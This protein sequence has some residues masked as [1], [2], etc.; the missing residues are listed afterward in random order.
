MGTI[1]R[2]IGSRI[3][4]PALSKVFEF[5]NILARNTLKMKLNVSHFLFY[6]IVEK[7]EHFYWIFAILCVS[8]YTW[9]KQTQAS[10]EWTHASCICVSITRYIVTAH[11]KIV[12]FVRSFFQIS[13]FVTD[14]R[15]TAVFGIWSRLSCLHSTLN[16]CPVPNDMPLV[17]GTGLSRPV[18]SSSLLQNWHL[19]ALTGA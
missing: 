6:E 3:S 19:F 2:C 17:F 18:L 16:R 15:N 13:C 10:G 8:N 7:F 1:S 11:P 5:R 14:S 12:N 9:I 4:S